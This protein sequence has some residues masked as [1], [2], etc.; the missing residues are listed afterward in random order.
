MEA[1][2]HAKSELKK[3]QSPATQNVV[4]N[5]GVDEPV[6]FEEK[7]RIHNKKI[8]LKQKHNVTTDEMEENS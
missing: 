6:D 5:N 1:I 7:K 8:S 3:I 4:D 2:E